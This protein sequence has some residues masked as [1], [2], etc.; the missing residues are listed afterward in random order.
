MRTSNPN[1][2]NWDSI[3]IGN[4]SASSSTDDSC[5]FNE[6]A[7]LDSRDLS[8]QVRQVDTT[9]PPTGSDETSEASDRRLCNQLTVH[10]QPVNEC[11]DLKTE[12]G[13]Q[14]NHN[15][16][17]LNRNSL[18]HLSGLRLLIILWITIGHSFLY[19]SANNYQYYRSII[20]MNITRDS[21]WFATTNFT[22]GIDMLLYMTGL[23]FVYKLAHLSPTLR[24]LYLNSPMSLKS[25]SRAYKAEGRLAMKLELK[26]TDLTG[27]IIKKML[28]FWPTY[29]TLIGMAILVPLVSDGPMWP[30]MVSKRLGESCR[31]NWWSNLLF[32]NNF[33]NESDICLP[34]SW[35]VSILMQLFLI[36]SLVILLVRRYSLR[37]ALIFLLVLLVISSGLSF[38]FAYVLNVRAPMIRMDESFVMELDES[39]FRLYTTIFNNL[40]PFL[41]GMIGGFLLVYAELTNIYEDPSNSPPKEVGHKKISCAN[42]YRRVLIRATAA[43][44]VATIAALVLSSVFHQDYSRFWAS[45]Y[46]S[47]HR[48]GWAIVTG[49]I[50]HNCATGRC[51]LL[52][53]VLSINAFVPINRLIPIAYLVYPIYIHMHSGLVR[54]GLHVSIYNMLNIYITRLVL[55]F[56]TALIVHLLVELPFCSL[57]ELYANKWICNNSNSLIELNEDVEKKSTK[58]HPL[59]AIAPTVTGI[60][61]DGKQSENT[62]EGNDNPSLEN[63]K[64]TCN[65]ADT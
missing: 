34:S 5:A 36:G 12:I 1:S 18:K 52:N 15:V 51:K 31:R 24:S 9:A 59:L 38:A 56:T 35:F 32:I 45:I 7:S 54:D 10:I 60:A 6:R 30:E 29:L 43:L 61:F 49:Y 25:A 21:V 16:H 4:K 17:K 44:V 22:L 20:N 63:D 11:A 37:I 42:I 40:G 65:N 28:R 57:V 58:L 55:T 3:K 50:I 26:A 33:L 62:V 64:K 46:W 23:L 8:D 13:Q 27:L 48:V 47:L 14:N 2:N 39:I 19:P 53:D 41:I